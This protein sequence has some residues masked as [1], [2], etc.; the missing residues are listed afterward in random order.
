[1]SDGLKRADEKK[2]EAKE[3]RPKFLI[4]AFSYLDDLS[5]PQIPHQ[6]ECPERTDGTEL[7]VN[8]DEDLE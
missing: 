8:P 4:S 3:T 6:T 7:K 1:M 5:S 2:S